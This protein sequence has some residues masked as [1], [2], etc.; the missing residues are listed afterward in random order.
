MSRR[1]GSRESSR[2]FLS[3]VCILSSAGD[4]SRA[5]AGITPLGTAFDGPLCSLTEARGSSGFPHIREENL[6]A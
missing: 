4:Q 2:P 3:E 5:L 6:P 1:E